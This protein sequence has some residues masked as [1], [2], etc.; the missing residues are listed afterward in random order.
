MRRLRIVRPCPDVPPAL[1]DA[2]ESTG[3]GFCERCGET[4]V[5]L[6]GPDAEST[7]LARGGRV[8]GRIAVAAAAVALGACSSVDATP[9][10]AAPT[11]PT[12][13]A[14]AP[15]ASAP[16]DDIEYGLVMID[17]PVAPPPSVSRPAPDPPKR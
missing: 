10:P 16:Y 6:S 15:D 8:C 2:V 12:V 17:E 11:A 9:L 4:V 1:R 3:T 14:S 5:D 13:T 7:L